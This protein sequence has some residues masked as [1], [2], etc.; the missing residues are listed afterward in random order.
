MTSRT[1]ELKAEVEV[2]WFDKEELVKKVNS[3]S[4]YCNTI[5][6]YES[7]NALLDKVL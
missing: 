3:N 6:E 5:N 2:I 1:K 4:D 7:Y